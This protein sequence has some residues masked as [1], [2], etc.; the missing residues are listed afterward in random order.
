MD[1]YDK[2]KFREQGNFQSGAVLVI[3]KPLHWTSFDVVNK[4]R[5]CL[6]KTCGKIKVGHAGTLDPLATG[7]V[8]VCVGKETKEIERYM[9][10][11]KEYIAELTFGHT[12]PS[13][14]LET[15]F[16]GDYDYQHVTES[17]LKEVVSQFE[18]EIE[19]FPPI[20]SAIR[21]DGTRAYERARKG[22]NVELKSRKIRIY[23]IEILKIDMPVVVLKVVCGKGTYIRSLVNDIGKACKSGAYLSA[24]KRTRV[25]NFSLIDGFQLNE[26]V[27][28]LRE[29]E[30]LKVVNNKI[31]GHEIIKV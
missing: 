13:F 29:C 25:G 2:I 20:Y 3:D 9:G 5:Y 28:L 19:Q 1:V 15:E 14:D 27:D 8:V 12:T 30:N 16:D 21:V 26:V 11:E 24:L 22:D 7:V 4:L 31:V 18:G 6:R 17:R 23:H 10:E